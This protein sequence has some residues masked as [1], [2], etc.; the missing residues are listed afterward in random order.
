ME[1]RWVHLVRQ[2]PC[3]VFGRCF[4]ER[5]DEHLH[6]TTP[7]PVGITDA[8]QPLAGANRPL[9]EKTMVQG[10][11]ITGLTFCISEV[12]LFSIDNILNREKNERLAVTG[13][14]V[15]YW[16]VLGRVPEIQSGASRFLPLEPSID[17]NTHHQC[18]EVRRDFRVRLPVRL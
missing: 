4:Y 1:Y 10:T 7:T 8:R 11:H 15:S 9:P 6:L 13:W 17:P 14:R 3:F 16:W 12:D 2:V 5:V 18:R